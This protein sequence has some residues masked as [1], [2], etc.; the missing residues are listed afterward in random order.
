[1]DISDYSEKL[2]LVFDRNAHESVLE[3]VADALILDVVPIDKAW[4]N[5]LEY[6]TQWHRSGLDNQMHVIGHQAIRIERIAALRLIL[7]K[8][9]HKYGIV[10]LLFKNALFIDAA[11]DNMVDSD[12]AGFSLRCCHNSLLSR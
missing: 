4:N 12:R 6:L 10:F 2:D 1:M 9:V 5:M 3:K 7:T 11:V 8:Y